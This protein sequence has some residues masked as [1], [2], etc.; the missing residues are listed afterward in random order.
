[1]AAVV[2]LAQ[3]Q[4]AQVAQVLLFLNIQMYTRQPLAVELHKQQQRQPV[5]LRFQQ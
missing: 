4:A 5:D 1:V 3:V 2:E